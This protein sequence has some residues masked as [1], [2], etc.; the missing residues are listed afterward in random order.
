MFAIACAMGTGLI[1]GSGTG[2]LRGGPGS[3]L[4]AYILTGTCV[5]FVMS[6][7]GEMATYIPMNKGFSGYASRY[8][9]PALGYVAVSWSMMTHAFLVFVC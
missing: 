5:F 7:L 8:F 9:H 3:L 1:I 2:L 4:I 6:A